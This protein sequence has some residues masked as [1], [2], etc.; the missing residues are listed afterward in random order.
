M[1]EQNNLLMEANPQDETL[2]LRRAS[3][4]NTV[5]VARN[6]QP[7]LSRLAANQPLPEG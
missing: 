6:S 3:V 2:T 1:T 7:H 5:D 4:T